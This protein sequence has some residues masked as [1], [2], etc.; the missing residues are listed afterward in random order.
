MLH[1]FKGGDQ[2]INVGA[3]PALLQPFISMANTRPKKD[4]KK[5]ERRVPPRFNAPQQKK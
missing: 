2:V 5:K 1:L 4:Q 3:A